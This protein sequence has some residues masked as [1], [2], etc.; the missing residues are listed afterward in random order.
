MSGQLPKNMREIVIQILAHL[1]SVLALM[2]KEIK[3]NRFGEITVACRL[4]AH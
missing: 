2:T 4:V 1:L 3:H